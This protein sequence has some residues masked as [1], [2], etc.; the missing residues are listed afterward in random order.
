MVWTV[1]TSQFNRRRYSLIVVPTLCT[2]RKDR[3][4]QF[5]DI[6]TRRKDRFLL[7]CFIFLQIV[8]RSIKDWCFFSVRKHGWILLY[9]IDSIRRHRV[10]L[11]WSIFTC[12]R[13]EYNN[14]AILNSSI[15]LMLFNWCIIKWMLVVQ[16]YLI[17]YLSSI[18]HELR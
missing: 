12:R 18:Q 14:L 9:A 10:D 3:S 8:Y 4:F 13:K 7:L 6:I 15:T 5:Y 17:N 16:W 1:Q 2:V 11:F